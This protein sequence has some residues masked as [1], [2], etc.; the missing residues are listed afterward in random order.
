MMLVNGDR[1]VEDDVSKSHVPVN[2]A[3]AE[4]ATNEK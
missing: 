3:D 1:M 4:I 2:E